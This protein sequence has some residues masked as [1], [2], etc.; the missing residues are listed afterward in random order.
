M[1][2][3]LWK[4]LSQGLQNA[5]YSKGTSHLYR[6]ESPE[7]GSRGLQESSLEVSILS[8]SREIYRECRRQD[9]EKP[10][11]GKLLFVWTFVTLR[12]TELWGMT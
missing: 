11:W 2:R 6:A 5:G 8:Q 3:L 4:T 1:D 7:V 10:K 12:G 9:E